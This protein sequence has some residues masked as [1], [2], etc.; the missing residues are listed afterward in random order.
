VGTADANGQAPNS[1][2]S[3]RYDVVIGD[4]SPP[5]DAD[6]HFVVNVTDVRKKSDLSDYAG[7]LQL[8]AALRITDR[9]NGT[10]PGGGTDSGTGD[11]SLPAT[12]PCATTVSTTI[13]S[14]C[15]LTTTFDAISPGVVLEGK[16]SVWEMGKINLFDGGP[17]GVASTSPNTLFETEGVFIP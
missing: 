8:D 9:N 14:T 4:P 12:V 6:V 3:V 13:G 17:D 10:G 2:G 7:Q 5:D 1:V 16:R 11:A 15:S